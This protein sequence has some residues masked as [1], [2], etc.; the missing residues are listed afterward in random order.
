MAD[1]FGRVLFTEIDYLKEGRNADRLRYALRSRN[2]V[3]IPRVFWKYTSKRVLTLEFLPGTKI[4]DIKTLAE[5]QID[6]G[7]LAKKL[8][9][10][11]MEQVLIHGLF[12]ADPHAGNLAVDA[13][14]LIIIYDFGVIG[15]INETQR[16]QIFQA[17]QAIVIQDTDKL[18]DSLLALG[19]LKKNKQSRGYQT[20]PGAVYRLL[21]RQIGSRL[22]L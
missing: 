14:G 11:Y 20:H 17:I 15:E 21:R 16:E 22:R 8:I 18:V 7:E 13:S 9:D 3:L 2:D 4:D 10:C 12:H 6:P 1:Q 19:M 5:R